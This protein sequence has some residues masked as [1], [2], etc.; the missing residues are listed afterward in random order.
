[1]VLLGVSLLGL[2][3]SF[4]GALVD[5]LGR[6]NSQEEYSHG[7]LIVGL[8][9]WLLWRRR[10]VLLGSLGPPSWAGLLLI[11]FAIALA[12]VS[13][14]S[15]LATLGH[16]AFVLALMG[17]CL[18]FGGWLF[19]RNSFVILAFLFFAIPLPG[20][21]DSALSL[22]LQLI[23]SEIA[24]DLIRLANIPVYVDGNIIDLGNYK[25][26]VADACSGLRYLF[27]LLSLGFLAAYFFKAPLYQRVTLLLS[28]IPITILMNS[29][30][31]AAIGLLVNVW[32]PSM[33]DGAL[34]W[35][36]GW[37]IFAAC[38]AV[39][40]AEM[41]IFARVFQ[42]KPL[43]EALRLP[44]SHDVA[45]AHSWSTRSLAAISRR[46]VPVASLVLIAFGGAG[47][48]TLAGRQE[49][50]PERAR[51]A[52]F[53]TAIEGWRG[54]SSALEPQIEHVL[55]LDDYILADFVRP[56]G[57]PI[58][59]YVAYYPSQRKGVARI[60]RS[61]VFREAAGRSLGLSA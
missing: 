39:L 51:F 48:W 49:V 23:S 20:F 54:R 4:R 52:S 8:V 57:K 43:F 11:S 35:F 30:R 33:A 12:A 59:L 56:N 25:L 32:G 31:I 58:N 26:Q 13:E 15:A 55:G 17:L 14:L 22:R 45:Q 10:A 34:H 3:L 38:A 6:W 24:G 21:L 53:P 41:A 61:S 60:H 40:V 7:Y 5:L 19:F 29:L 50:I 37:V 27:P 42:R 44:G 16:I 9:L 1:M 2:V 46:A 18:A 36:E 47:L 28:T